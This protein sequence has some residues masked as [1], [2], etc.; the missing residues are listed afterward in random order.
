M[1]IQFYNTLTK[2]KEEFTPQEKG[3]VRMYNCGP[4]VYSYPHIGNF[5]SF[6]FADVLRRYLEYRGMEVKQVMNITDVGH[7]TAD[8][9]EGEDK[10]EAQAK[11]EK[12]DP[13]QIAAHY[14]GIFLDLRK[15]LG[16]ADALAHPKATEHIPEMIAI[17]EKLVAKGHAYVVGNNVYFSVATFPNYGKLSG[18]ITEDLEAGARIEPHPDKKDPRDFALWK[19]DPKHIMQ[20]DSPWGRGFPGWH[21]EC[22]A[23]S[24]KYLGETLDIHTG[25]EDNI[26]PHHECE[27]AQSEAANGK[28]FCRM[29]MHARFLLVDGQKMSK[30]AGNFYTVEDVFRHG[31]T[32]P[33]LRWGL[34]TSHYRQQM[35]FTW[36]SMQVAQG[37]VD[38]LI[39]FRKRLSDAHGKAPLEAVKPVVEKARKDF[40]KGMDDDLNV[41]E[42]T[43]AL[44]TMVR[45]INRLDPDPAAAAFVRDAFDKLDTVFNTASAP[46]DVFTDEEQ[47]LL[48]ARAAAR[49]SKNWP[50][51]DRLRKELEAKGVL[52]E[53]TARGQRPRRARK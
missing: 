28:P 26:F 41:S 9:D 3:V 46:P 24:M 35:N 15:Q 10:M 34:A 49:S 6:V 22:S 43:A 17:I 36:E 31:V 1:A 19:H 14:G 39:E 52:V 18:N 23:M 7:I 32:A 48:A 53:D 13:W 45:E 4:T 51:S 2:Q 20:W 27:I 11:K 8:A 30:S 33:A 50:E 21:I 47:K 29:W 38:K 12:K 37:S 42:A 44:F 25:G 40:E 16:F 5:R